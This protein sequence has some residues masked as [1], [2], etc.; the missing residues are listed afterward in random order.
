MALTLCV[1]VQATLALPRILLFTKTSPGAYRHDS[2]PTAVDVITR[3]GTGSLVLNDSV[4][5]PLVSG[6]NAKWESV[7]SEDDSL[8][9]SDG[10]YLS[11]FDAIAFIS[12]S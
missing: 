5:D 2:I 12:T 8:W 4:A 3:I 9:T 1:C 7:H 11:Q 10:S 6:S